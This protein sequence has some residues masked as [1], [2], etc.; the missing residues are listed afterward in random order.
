MWCTYK[1][2]HFPCSSPHCHLLPDA[3]FL[4]GLPKNFRAFVFLLNYSL[5]SFLSSDLSYQSL[6]P[7]EEKGLVG[8]GGTCQLV[9]VTGYMR[10]CFSLVSSF[11]PQVLRQHRDMGIIGV[12]AWDSRGD[13]KGTSSAL[14]P[15]RR[16]MLSAET[17][18]QNPREWCGELGK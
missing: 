3:S 10:E 15:P 18:T 8:A 12:R 6:R 16:E 17:G 7:V 1:A 5:E 4:S 11:L 14:L 9:C 2:L 13:S